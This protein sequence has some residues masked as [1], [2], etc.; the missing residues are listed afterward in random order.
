MGLLGRKR[1][2]SMSAFLYFLRNHGFVKPEFA[3]PSGFLSPMKGAYCLGPES[4]GPTNGFRVNMGTG[5]CGINCDACRLNVRGICSSCGA[6]T[7]IAGRRKLEAQERLFHGACPVL[8]CAWEHQISYCPRD[9]RRFPC[10]LF[11]Q[12]PYPYSRGFLDMQRRRRQETRS[13][14]VSLDAMS[15]WQ[16]EEIDAA[17]WEEL[18]AQDPADV[19]RRSLGSYDS[20]EEVYRIRL[21]DQGVAIHPFRRSIAREEDDSAGSHQY[22]DVLFDEALV[23]VIYLLRSKEIPLVGKQHTEKD[24]PGGETFFRGPHELARRPILERYGN[25][26]QGFHRAAAS[27]GG[28]RLDF[29][30][31]SFRLPALPRVP[32]DYILWAQDNEFPARLTFAFD[33]TVSQH[34]PLD[35]IW[36]LVNL[37]SRK[38]VAAGS[39]SS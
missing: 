7:E 6:G 30:D 15:Q 38:L 35:V 13:P 18:I 22:G 12:G 21:L 39:V 1:N 27:L 25:D 26:P 19:C 3:Y 2:A 36:A 37:T 9:C 24:L 11:E 14:S 20:K 17:Y 8:K 29:G 33:P 5:A 23:L 4:E 32:L 10:R 28:K 31:A 34:L 16:Q